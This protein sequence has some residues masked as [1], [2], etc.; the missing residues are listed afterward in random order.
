MNNSFRNGERNANADH[1]NVIIDHEFV[2]G[3]GTR[4]AYP[5]RAHPVW[6]LHDPST[7]P[8][9]LMGIPGGP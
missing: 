8:D 1:N 6:P 5:P 7:T 9:R 3:V 4:L 2:N